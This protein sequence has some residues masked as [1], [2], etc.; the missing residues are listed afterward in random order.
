MN[1]TL[2]ASWLQWSAAAFLRA[3]PCWWLQT[4]SDSTVLAGAVYTDLRLGHDIFGP[5]PVTQVNPG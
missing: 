2:S 3:A 1:V 5:T 4:D